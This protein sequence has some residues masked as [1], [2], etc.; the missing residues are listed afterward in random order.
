L[1]HESEKESLDLDVYI[2]ETKSEENLTKTMYEW[3]LVMERYSMNI[4]VSI[5]K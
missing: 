2:L 5:R 1:K 4:K 3:N